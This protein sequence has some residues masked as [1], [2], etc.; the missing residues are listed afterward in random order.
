MAGLHLVA[1]WRLPL[2]V[3]WMR[4]VTGIPCPGCGSTR[5]LMALAR[6][7]MAEAFRLNPMVFTA[8]VLLIGWLL[9]WTADQYLHRQWAVRVSKRIQRLPLAVIIPL[10]V[11]ANWIYL[12]FALPR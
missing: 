10:I 12:Y 7:D 3:C 4:V 9:L 2:P 5:C 6:F 11:V 8:F 1:Q